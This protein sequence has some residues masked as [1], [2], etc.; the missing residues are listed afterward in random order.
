MADTLRT[1]GWWLRPRAVQMMFDI[2]AITLSFVVFQLIRQIVVPDIRQFELT[3]YALISMVSIPYWVAVFWMGGLYR[4]FYVRSPFDEFFT[5][6]R[7]TFY[8]TTVAF[9]MIFLSSSEYDRGRPRLTIV[10]YLLVITALVCVGRALARSVQRWLREHGRVQIP[11]LMLGTQESLTA[12]LANVR[13]EPAWGYAVQGV[14][15]TTS[16]EKWTDTSVPHR[17]TMNDVR[18]ILRRD[19]PH[20]LLVSIP[21]ADHDT[22]LSL[23]ATCADEGVTVKIVPDL[24]EIFSGQ[25]RTQQIYGSPLIEVSPELM[26]PWEEFAKRMLD[27]VVSVLILVI[28]LPLWIIVALGVRLSS[29]GPVFYS[30]DRTGKGGRPFRMYKFRSMVVDVNRAPSW[31]TVNDPRVTRFGWFIRK[32]HLD[33]IP[34]LWNVL[35][36]DMSLVGPRPEIPFFVEKYSALIPYYRRRLKVRPGV[37]GWWQVKYKAY[38]ESVEEI[39]NRLRYDFFYIENMSFKLDLEILVRTAFIMIKGHG[40]A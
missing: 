4:D 40:Q 31:T 6:A 11:T 35:R 24:Y 26:Q 33:E 29:P 13:R 17:G 20:Q 22:M 7:Q 36:G 16:D 10:L 14:V 15:T 19:Q 1:G 34:Q 32:T 18:E 38:E 27:I 39:E 25:A 3:D 28:G 9:L 21:H 8:G 30:Q 37:T 12:L 5:V 23:S 2:I